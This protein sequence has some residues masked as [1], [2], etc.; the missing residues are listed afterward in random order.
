MALSRNMSR[1]DAMFH[2]GLAS[3]MTFGIILAGPSGEYLWSKWNRGVIIL[4]DLLPVG[5]LCLRQTCLKC[6]WSLLSVSRQTPEVSFAVQLLYEDLQDRL[7]EQEKKVSGL[8][9]DRQLP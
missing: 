2:V 1:T 7:A 4:N 6:Q 5:K 3:L 9:A 8:G